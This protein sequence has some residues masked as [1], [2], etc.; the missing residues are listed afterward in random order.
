MS[1]YRFSY[2]AIL[3]NFIT[4]FSG[5]VKAG[6]LKV[7]KNMDND[8]MYSVYLNRGQGSITCSYVPLWIYSNLCLWSYF[9]E[10]YTTL[11]L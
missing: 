8:W 5:T 10:T 9:N 3:E 4:D 1:L 11:G 2:F 7:G 6:K